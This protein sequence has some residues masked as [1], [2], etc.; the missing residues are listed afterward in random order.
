MEDLDQYEVAL[1][2]N[3]FLDRIR[4]LKPKGKIVRLIECEFLDWTLLLAWTM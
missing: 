1:A 4:C 2:C 3:S